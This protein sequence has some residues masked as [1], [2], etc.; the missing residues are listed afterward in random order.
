[1][2]STVVEVVIYEQYKSILEDAMSE[3]RVRDEVSEFEAEGILI[4][5]FLRRA[6]SRDSLMQGYVSELEVALSVVDDQFDA[7]KERK[8]FGLVDS[9][10]DDD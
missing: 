9:W 6:A 7:D 1:M 8:K 10:G 5:W 2:G 3:C 4:N